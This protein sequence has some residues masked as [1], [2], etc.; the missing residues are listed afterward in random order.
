L[1][2]ITF[3]I[4]AQDNVVINRV[5]VHELSDEAEDNDDEMDKWERQQFQ[6]AIRQRQVELTHQ[7]MSFQQHIAVGVS[8]EINASRTSSPS[9]TG[10]TDASVKGPSVIPSRAKAPPDLTKL[11]PL[12]TPEEL[13]A[14]LRDRFVFHV[15]QLL[16]F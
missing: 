6:K 12:P 5:E 10:T 9:M 7:D 1:V 3:S 2:K 8:S 13:Q 11:A 15:T 16:L 14:K 4:L